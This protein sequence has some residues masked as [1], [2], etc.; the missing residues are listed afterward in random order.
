MVIEVHHSEA[1]ARAAARQNGDRRVAVYKY[2]PAKS[3]P[4]EL[5]HEIHKPHVEPSTT[6]TRYTSRE[7]AI[8]AAHELA[9]ELGFTDEQFD[10]SDHADYVRRTGDGDEYISV[11]EA[12]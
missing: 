9:R 11:M 6:R 8:E 10:G 12:E 1:S 3:L 2:T 7:A 5:V 4:F